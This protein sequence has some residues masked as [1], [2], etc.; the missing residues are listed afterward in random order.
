MR[1]QA[2]IMVGKFGASGTSPSRLPMTEMEKTTR[3]QKQV[4]PAPALQA[5]INPSST[6]E[7]Y[8]YGMRDI[9][10]Q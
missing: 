7:P 5:G 6:N 10:L 3:K 9:P 8:G 2:K 4:T 1:Q